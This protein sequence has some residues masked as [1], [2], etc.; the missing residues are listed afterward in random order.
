[1]YGVRGLPIHMIDFI[2]WQNIE[3]RFRSGH[4]Q[5]VAINHDLHR[6]TSVGGKSTQKVSRAFDRERVF[7]RVGLEGNKWASPKGFK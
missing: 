3:R 7:A 1:M 5:S 4:I 6:L 2:E